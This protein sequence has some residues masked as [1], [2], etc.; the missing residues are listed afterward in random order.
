MPR[1]S[2]K[3][4]AGLSQH[5]LAQLD[6]K[7]KQAEAALDAAKVH[8]AAIKEE[9]KRRADAA[10][11]AEE[12]RLGKLAYAAGL[13]GVEAGRLEKAFADLAAKVVPVETEEE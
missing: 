12:V 1:T 13:A 3:K 5:T 7:K 10:Q 4:P 6:A 11:Y 2:A 8:L 9:E